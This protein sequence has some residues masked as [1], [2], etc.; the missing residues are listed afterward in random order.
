MTVVNYRLDIEKFARYIDGKDLAKLTL[1]D[2]RN[3][4]GSQEAGQASAA[5]LKRCLSA[6]KN[7][8]KWLEKYA[9]IRNTA[10]ITVRTR[11]PRAALPRPIDAQ[12]IDEMLAS[13][14]ETDKPLRNR[15]LVTLLFA[16]GL[17]ISECLSLK[18]KDMSRDFLTITGKGGKERI[19]P[20]IPAARQA[21]ERYLETRPGDSADAL[22]F[23]FTAR[24][25]QNMVKRAREKL[26]LPDTVT[27]HA[28]RHSFAT[29]LLKNGADLRV[30]QQL[31]GHSSLTTTQRYAELDIKQ[32]LDVHGKAK[33]E[34]VVK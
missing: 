18:I 17:R 26:G 20:V 11:K 19:V 33:P 16:T 15:A 24:E 1:R 5:S 7:W 29:A 12:T 28:L 8:F 30:I 21:V 10:I 31:L 32:L 14:D 25:A 22:V 3:F 13:L 34:S 23:P 9:G 2:F 27:P 6:L 4:L